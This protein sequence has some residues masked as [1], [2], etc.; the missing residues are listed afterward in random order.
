MIINPQTAIDEGWITFPEEPLND[1][2]LQPN[3][4]DIRVK[5]AWKIP[6]HKPFRLFNH[7][8]FHLDK[9]RCE[10][11]LYEDHPT[12]LFERGFAYSVE[13]FEFV[14]VPSNVAALVYGRSSLNRNGIFCRATLYDSGF[15]DFV[16]FTMYPFVPFE[17]HFGARVAQIIFIEADSCHLYQGQYLLNEAERRNGDTEG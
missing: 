15:T 8:T 11:S 2:Q 10:Q 1:K 13:T 16:G 7:K 14:K 17:V 9:Y 6:I 12:F 4:I 5:I 3:G